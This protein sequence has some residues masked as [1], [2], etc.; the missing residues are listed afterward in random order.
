MI[1]GFPEVEIG[2]TL[3]APD[4]PIPLPRL[5]VDEPVLRMTF[6]VNTSPLAVGSALVKAIAIDTGA[7]A[8]AGVYWSD[9]L[10]MPMQGDVCTGDAGMPVAP[11]APA[12]RTVSVD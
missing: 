8:V 4:D 2:D 12:T 10:W 6:G 7:P 3:A 11:R 5:E 9:A 1:A